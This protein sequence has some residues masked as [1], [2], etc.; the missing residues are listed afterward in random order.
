MKKNYF[1]KVSYFLL[2]I[3]FLTLGSNSG[4]SFENANY[5]PSILSIENVMDVTPNIASFKALPNGTEATLRLNNAQVLFVGPNDTYVRDAS[6]AIDF[7]RT[8]ITFVQG[9][10]LNGEIMGK[11]TV[12]YKTP[13]L[14]K[15]NNTNINSITFSEGTA[16]PKLLSI[17]QVKSE[18]YF[19]DLVKIQGVKLVSKE[20]GNNTNIYAYIGNDSIQV[21]DK[22][23]VGLG[24][25]NTT[26][27]YEIEGI[28]L[29]YVDSYEIAPTKPFTL[30]SGN[31][32]QPEAHNISFK[33]PHVK[34][35]CVENWDK[36]N[37]GELSEDEAAV[38]TSLEWTFFDQKDITS[39]DE[40]QYFKGVTKLSLNEFQGCSNLNS[41]VLPPYLE[42]IAGKSS[43]F[44][45]SPRDYG[46]F[47]N[48]TSLS[49]III[50]NSV[51]TI[52]PLAFSNTGLTSISI[53]NS[54][55]SLEEQAFENCAKLSSV[56]LH[57]GLDAIFYQCFYGC[58]NLTDIIIPN[59]L[60]YIGVR[61]F[62]NTGI[63]NI[64]LPNSLEILGAGAFINCESL[65]S[66][67]LPKSLET[68]E[69][70]YSFEGESGYL[71]PFQGCS[72][73]T[74]IQVEEGNPN[75][76]SRDNCNAIILSDDNILITGCA[77]STIP[78]TVSSIEIVAF[79][80]CKGLTSIFIP[81]SV[82]IIGSLAFLGCSGLRTVEIPNT[83][84]NIGAGVFNGCYNL[85]N[86]TV[87]K[88]VKHAND[89]PMDLDGEYKSELFI[90]NWGTFANCPNLINVWAMSEV[91]P[92]ID[93]GTI[94]NR[95]NATLIVPAGCKAKY[96]QAEYWK[97]FRKILEVGPSFSS[98]KG[99]VN[100]DGYVNMSDVTTII[101]IILGKIE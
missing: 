78:N 1:N 32:E 9:Q 79:R 36:D 41:I 69:F 62:A 91:P 6:G 25:W 80:D 73:L 2:A 33:D 22:F 98:I 64:I 95:E 43:K 63:K 21:Y 89:I 55:K 61:A 96:E 49:Q 88:V 52:G 86:A 38:V 99:D 76:D 57:D 50:P 18:I 54:V 15:T 34:T 13:E 30:C 39:F 44:S 20:D 87:N 82:K 35:I 90:L 42:I 67:F 53:P 28:L 83:V 100:G 27:N 77:G 68:I 81:S 45:D 92:V 71:T 58:K 93:A 74:S 17:P 4:Y 3:L 7:Y 14:T 59:S 26:N 46:P 8:G 94:P 51:I 84:E 12:Y 23:K 65:R 16:N 66:A 48:C 47:L 101:N 40:F 72:N 97:D 75:Y 37:D 10:I 19:C 70:D 11:S 85:T 5:V 60:V 29:P 24:E 56:S 31:I